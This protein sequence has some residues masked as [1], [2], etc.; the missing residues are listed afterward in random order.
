MTQRTMMIRRSFL[1]LALA[2]SVLHAQAQERS[3]LPYKDPK[4]PVEKRVKDLLSRMTLEE[5]LW[6]LFMGP[7]DPSGSMEKMRHG[8]FGLQL[9]TEAA[10]SKIS[11]Q[12]LRYDSSGTARAAAERANIMQRYFL[13]Q[14]RLG[15]PIIPFDEALHG[16]VR[17]GATS[18]PQSIALA[19]TWDTPLM[20]QVAHAVALET[21]TRG[22]RQVL[23]P[24]VNVATDVR[25][26]RVEET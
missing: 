5:K 7:P 13:T 16:L 21:R 11:E 4:V 18:F 9:A 14:T 25:W 22:I 26:G 19:A 2:A 15:I 1:F 12:I 10:S 17:A 6:Q 8:I 24:V 23:S 20:S 3:I